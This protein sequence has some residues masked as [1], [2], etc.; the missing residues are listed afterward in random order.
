MIGETQKL[1]IDDLAFGRMTFCARTFIKPTQQTGCSVNW[2]VKNQA[3]LQ[4]ERPD[5]GLWPKHGLCGPPSGPA[6]SAQV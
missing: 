4:M 5:G 6:G 1:V 3:Q 2:S